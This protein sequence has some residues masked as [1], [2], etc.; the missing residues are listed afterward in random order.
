MANIA[1]PVR[2]ADDERRALVRLQRS[3]RAPAGLVRRARA[4]LLMAGGIPGSEVARR[5]GYTPVQVSRIRQRFCDERLAGL[6]D[7]ARSGRPR[8]VTGR[9]TARIV[10]LTLK[11]PP[12][13]VTHWSSRDLAALVGSVSHMTVHRIWRAH[14]L[15]PHRG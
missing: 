9:T 4:V 1:R 3:S 2:M 8:T 12:A 11:P 15:Q 6:G 5:T 7:R 14:A 10:A 13:G